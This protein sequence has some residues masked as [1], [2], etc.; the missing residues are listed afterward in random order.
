MR[1]LKLSLRAHS[2]PILI[3]GDLLGRADLIQPFLR[4][5]RVALVSNT[6]VAPAL[7]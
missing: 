1:R 3:G 4:S 7:L 2:Y 6:T 5:P